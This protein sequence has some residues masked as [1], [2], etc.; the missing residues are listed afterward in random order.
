MDYF[1]SSLDEFCCFVFGYLSFDQIVFTTLTKDFSNKSFNLTVSQPDRILP[2]HFSSMIF[3]ST[4]CHTNFFQ[5]M[6]MD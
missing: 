1:L 6:L 3:L 2:F 4:F 5:L